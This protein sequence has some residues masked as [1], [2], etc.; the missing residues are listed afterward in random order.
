MNCLFEALAEI[1]LRTRARFIPELEDTICDA[2]ENLEACRTNLLAKDR[3]LS[4]R[5]TDLAR[6]AL[7]RRN[8]G[9]LP[10]ARLHLQERRR[11][12]ARLDKL[13]NG[14][15]LLDKQLDALR[16]SE[17]DKELMHSLRVSTQ[18]MK[19]AGIG[20]G[21]EEAEKVMIE[22]DDQ[23]READDITTLLSTPLLQADND[24]DEGDLDA[25]LD[26]LCSE[27]ADDL[28]LRDDTASPDSELTPFL[29]ARRLPVNAMEPAMSR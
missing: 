10:A 14:V 21:V 25:E 9:D 29:P 12:S 26:L 7:R 4:T 24:I 17:L 22:A 1:Y 11:C 18:A 2:E 15:A 3:E 16:S 23:I 13:R 19:K 28:A 5:C 6:D 27:H 8:A 20:I